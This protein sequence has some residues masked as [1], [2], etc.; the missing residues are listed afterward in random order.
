MQLAGPHLRLPTQCAPQRRPSHH[1]R[2]LVRMVPG[3][4][5]R[6]VRTVPRLCDQSKSR[7]TVLEKAN[8]TLLNCAL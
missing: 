8:E 2:V 4:R 3:P 1:L 7:H 6:L 5:L